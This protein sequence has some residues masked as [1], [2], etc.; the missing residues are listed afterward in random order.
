MVWSCWS[1]FNPKTPI[2]ERWIRHMASPFLHQ[3]LLVSTITF[4]FPWQWI[5]LK[6]I[7]SQKY[8]LQA[9]CS[10]RCFGFTSEH[11]AW[12]SGGPIFNTVNAAAPAALCPQQS[13]SAEVIQQ[14]MKHF[15]WPWLFAPGP[16]QPTS[17]ACEREAPSICEPSTLP[18]PFHSLSLSTIL[19]C[20]ICATIWFA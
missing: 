14:N 1:F 18:L 4:I 5:L 11:G 8:L 19:G 12:R 13:Q 9:T 20:H 16:L 17:Q 10:C 6:I 2:V 3:Q 15:P 7:R